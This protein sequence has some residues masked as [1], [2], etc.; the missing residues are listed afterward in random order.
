MRELQLHWTREAEAQPSDDT[1]KTMVALFGQRPDHLVCFYDYAEPIPWPMAED[2][3]QIVTG[4]QR[5]K[6]QTFVALM[7]VGEAVKD[8]T[9]R[10]LH[11]A[12][13]AKYPKAWAA[14]LARTAAGERHALELG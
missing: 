13:K 6:D 3:T 14:Y 1:G 11:E 5:F 8:Y 2:G 10:P 9:S 4:R 7:P 12:D